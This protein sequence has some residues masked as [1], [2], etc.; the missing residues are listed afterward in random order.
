MVSYIYRGNGCDTTYTEI[1]NV[2]VDLVEPSFTVD[3]SF[4]CS[5]SGDILLT[6]TSIR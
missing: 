6:N 3:Q 5:D 2:D 4:I 1:H